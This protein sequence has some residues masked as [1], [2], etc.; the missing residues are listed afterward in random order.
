MIDKSIKIWM[1]S[2]YEWLEPPGTPTQVMGFISYAGGVGWDFG[3]AT[4]L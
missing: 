3:Q 1:P 2:I 4:I